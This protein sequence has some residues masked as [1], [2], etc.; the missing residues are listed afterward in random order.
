MVFMKE[1]LGKAFQCDIKVLKK[2]QLFCYSCVK[3]QFT[4]MD[5][6]KGDL[7]VT[8]KFLIVE[9]EI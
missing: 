3:F 4:N 2:K 1:K 7:N 6:V 9:T 8:V 5:F